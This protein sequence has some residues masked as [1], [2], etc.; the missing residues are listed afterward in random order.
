MNLNPRKFIYI[1]FLW[2]LIFPRVL[3]AQA[4]QWESPETRQKV[5]DK[6]RTVDSFIR[7]GPFKEKLTSLRN[8]QAPDWYRDAKF[9]V[10][11]HWG[12]YS[13]PGYANEWYP[14]NMY[15]PGNDAFKHQVA[16]FGPQT[17]FGYKD[18]IP[19]FKAERFD[20]RHWAD[21]FKKAGAKY[22]VP[23]AEH[24]EGFAMYDSD[25]SRWTAVKMGPKRDVIA[26]LAQAVR[27]EGLVF[28]LSTHRAEHWWFMNGG[29][30]FPSDVQDPAYADFYG[31]AQ[32]DGTPPDEEYLSNWLARCAEL[33]DKYHP[34]VMGDFDWW[35]GEQPAFDPYVRKLKAYYFNRAAQWKEGVVLTAKEK[36]FIPGTSVEDVEKGKFPGINPVP[37][38]TDT[39]VSWRSWAYLKDD[40]LKDAGYLIRFLIDTVSR[41][42]NLLLDIGPR[43]DGTIPEEQERVL[44][45]IGDWLKVNGEAIYGTRPWITFG[46]G[47]TQEMGGGFSESDM[48]YQEGD[49][50][51]TRKG[52]ALYAICMV[53]PSKPLT[54]THLGKF[55]CPYVEIQK[56]TKLGSTEEV[57]WDRQDQAVVISPSS[58]RG[59]DPI[60]YKAQLSGYLMGG[61]KPR[62]QGDR[63][64][65]SGFIQ[66][67][68][69]NTVTKEIRFGVL[70][71]TRK[72][73]RV[74]VGGGSTQNF[75]FS[76]Q[77]PHTGIYQ[78][79]LLCSHPTHQPDFSIQWQVALPS[80]G[81]TGKWLF[82][83]GDKAEWSEPSLNDASWDK[84]KVPAQ[85][86]AMGYQCE[87]CYGWYR[88]HLSIPKEWKGHG[89]VLPLGKIDDADITYFNGKEIGRMGTF[90][91]QEQTAWNR[92][93][94]YEVP[95]ELIHFGKD[96]VIAIRVYNGTG[97]AGLYDGPLGPVEVQ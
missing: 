39:S 93:R 32:A 23:V 22:V 21:L 47:P 35:I 89:L 84:V 94:R 87:H 90:P 16:T 60:V 97:G 42:G 80:L 29:M 88:L 43:P 36:T 52:N 83:K 72:S 41:N 34:Q 78:T 5:N 68:D 46:E 82:Q 69:P 10:F 20:A 15:Q 38:Q 77:N 45:R 74:T 85:W 8:Y 66:N 28:G 13:V 44:L 92:V 48:K 12:P 26:D 37:W 57:K 17:K 64:T 18:F 9:G 27:D 91:P 65:I 79:S 4:P 19:L 55:E 67:Y 59:N 49:V 95:A 70:P 63:V 33:V 76:Y 51:F 73:K 96:N 6:I 71:K 81:L 14:R 24:H 30:K 53:P 11:I 50:R 1:P 75:D 2:I 40:Q 7:K 3:F 25:F 86:E 54:L 58:R 61:V 31:P 56:I 62:I